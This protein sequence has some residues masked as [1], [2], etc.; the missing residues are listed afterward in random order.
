MSR[1]SAGRLTGRADIRSMATGWP[2]DDAGT[3]RAARTIPGAT[4]MEFLIRAIVIGAGA[5]VLL[6]IW[7]QLL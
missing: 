4:T 7:A 5:T 3:I 6:D 2:K 1:M